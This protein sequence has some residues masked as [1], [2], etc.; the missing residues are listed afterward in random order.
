MARLREPGR[1]PRRRLRYP[2]LRVLRRENQAPVQPFPL[3]RPR[4]LRG[5]P[6]YL[7][8]RHRERQ[9]GQD[10]GPDLQGRGRSTLSLGGGRRDLLARSR[11]ASARPSSCTRTPTSAAC[12][13]A[14]SPTTRRT[15]PPRLWGRSAIDA[16]LGHVESPAPPSRITAP[17]AAPPIAPTQRLGV[18]SSTFERYGLGSTTGLTKAENDRL[19]DAIVADWDA[20]GRD[21]KEMQRY[22]FQSLL[23][24][25]WGANEHKGIHQWQTCAP[26]ELRQAI[27]TGE[28]YRPRV[29]YEMSGNKYAVMGPSL[30]WEE[31]L[32]RAGLRHPAVPQHDLV[33]RADRRLV[34]AHHRVARATPTP[35]RR[36]APTSTA[37]TPAAR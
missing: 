34:P 24:T 10:G 29:M 36:R 15:P 9:G 2:G 18:F 21:G 22:F 32:R 33:H 13:T 37:T 31:G 5:R 3:H 20:K 17:P 1:R 16:L 23:R 30:E 7:R 4:E 27:T 6:R 28:R 19:L 25:P 12:P 26:K 14:R 11:N 35:T 8:H